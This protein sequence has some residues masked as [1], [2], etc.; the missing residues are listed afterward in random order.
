MKPD[1]QR[2]ENKCQD[3]FSAGMLSH[4]PEQ[5]SATLLYTNNW[6][7][8]WDHVDMLLH[9]DRGKEELLWST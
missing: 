6:A 8:D 5:S 7:C 4:E 3:A 2:L 1:K 9:L